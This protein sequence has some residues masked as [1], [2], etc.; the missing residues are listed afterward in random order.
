M[1]VYIHR[2]RVA[3]EVTE[4]VWKSFKEIAVT[5]L[6]KSQSLLRDPIQPPYLHS[7]SSSY[8][9]LISHSKVKSRWPNFQ[10]MIYPSTPR[11]VL[12]FSFCL[13]HPPSP[14]TLKSPQNI[15]LPRFKNYPFTTLLTGIWC[16][17]LTYTTYCKTL[18]FCLKK[19]EYQQS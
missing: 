13:A 17:K 5:S 11:H 14:I 1:C 4:W 7:P 19:E 6:K 8:L 2:H 3:S 16:F 15:K 12:L 18:L 10:I 9:L